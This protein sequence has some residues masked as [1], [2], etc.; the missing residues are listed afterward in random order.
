[1]AE[2]R[3][4]K[5]VQDGGQSP[6]HILENGETKAFCGENCKGYTY[7][8]HKPQAALENPEH[9]NICTFCYQTYLDNH[10]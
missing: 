6:Y 4:V 2:I 3:L 10:E 8:I 1:M 9:A 5:D 7:S